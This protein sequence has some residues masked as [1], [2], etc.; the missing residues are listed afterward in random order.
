VDT[1]DWKRIVDEN[2]GIRTH[3]GGKK[4]TSRTETYYDD[5]LIS[6]CS[7]Q[8]QKAS[9]IVGQAITKFG[10]PTGDIYL[11]W[12][13]RKLAEEGRLQLQGDIAKTLKDYD[14]KLPGEVIAATTVGIP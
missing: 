7:Q 10:I 2:A 4:L 5:Q 1:D 9:R 11:G 14:V 13:L 6:F 3:E 12:R 8:F